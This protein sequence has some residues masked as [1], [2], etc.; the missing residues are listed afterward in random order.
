MKYTA[1]VRRPDGTEYESTVDSSAG[2]KAAAEL[3]KNI[4]ES[5]GHELVGLKSADG[6]EIPMP[7]DQNKD[8]E[9]RVD[10]QNKTTTERVESQE[11][12]TKEVSPNKT[13]DVKPNR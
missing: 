6:E 8:T 4:A 12:D 1:T 9:E 3:A 10:E 7:D 5:Y 11:V 2:D 13:G